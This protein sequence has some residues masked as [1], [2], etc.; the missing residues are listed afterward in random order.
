MPHDLRFM[1]HA[2]CCTVE[3][4]FERLERHTPDRRL[5]DRRED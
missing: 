1:L 3:H 4:M 5:R 2:V